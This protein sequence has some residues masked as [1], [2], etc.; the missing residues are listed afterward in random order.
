MT[1]IDLES[2]PNSPSDSLVQFDLQASH[3][4]KQTTSAR[5][6]LTT[7]HATNALYNLN[8]ADD[9]TTSIRQHLASLA[10]QNRL[11]AKAR[12]AGPATV[13]IRVNRFGKLVRD[14][15]IV[16]NAL[17]IAREKQRSLAEIALR[18]DIVAVN[19]KLASKDVDTALTS[20]ALH[21]V[22]KSHQTTS[23]IEQLKARNRDLERLTNGVLTLREMFLELNIMVEKQQSLINDVEHD[24]DVVVDSVEKAN[25][26]IIMAQSYQKKARKKKIIILF[27]SVLVV[28]IVAIIIML[29]VT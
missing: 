29:Q 26:E 14:F 24:V 11:V 18:E 5:H 28:I 21:S 27:V 13:Q 25:D 22:L 6:L 15:G 8:R 12:T 16:V 19:P 23:Q 2:A 20:N 7:L 4:E 9:L 17:Q 10:E 1:E 3:I